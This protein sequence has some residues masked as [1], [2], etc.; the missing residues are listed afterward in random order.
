[1]EQIPRRS[2]MRGA[3][4]SNANVSPRDSRFSQTKKNKGGDKT[5][6]LWKDC[7]KTMKCPFG[8]EGA[9]NGPKGSRKTEKE[10][11]QGEREKGGERRESNRKQRKVLIGSSC[12]QEILG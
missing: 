10:H 5:K 2:L 4:D 12:A 11:D 8:K 6:R 9:G 3:R 1:M 7:L